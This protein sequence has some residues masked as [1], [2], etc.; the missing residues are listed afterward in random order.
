MSLDIQANLASHRQGSRSSTF[1]LTPDDDG[2]RVRVMN[3]GGVNVDEMSYAE[4]VELA[5]FLV[6]DL[7]FGANLTMQ[8]F[9]DGQ[10]GPNRKADRAQYVGSLDESWQTSADRH[11]L[12]TWIN[13]QDY[14]R[15]AGDWYDR[16]KD[17]YKER[18]Y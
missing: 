18:G 11:D 15:I 4:R 5:R 13:H 2:L 1:A 6:A 16:I 14:S 10:G 17:Y 3:P 12:L 9:A 7:P 8:A